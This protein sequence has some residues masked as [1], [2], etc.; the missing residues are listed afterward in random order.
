VRIVPFRP[1]HAQ[2]L[3]LREFD[4]LCL[5]GLPPGLDRAALWR[6]YHAAGPGFTALAGDEVV[7]CGGVVL[8]R[9]EEGEGWA[10]TGP[11]V[12]CHALSFHRAFARLL[13]AVEEECGLARVTT[14]VHERHAVS[15]RWLRRLGFRERLRRPGLLG[16]ENYIHCVREKPC[17]P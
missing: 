17:H 8:A 7:A 3:R 1:E 5:A 6:F 13:P 11:S 12:P 14:L 2:A 16:G 9:P 4:E 10:L 15:R